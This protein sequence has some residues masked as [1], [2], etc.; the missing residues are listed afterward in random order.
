MNYGWR[1][2]LSGILSAL[3]ASIN[4]LRDHGAAYA[5][6]GA[7][8]IASI[9]FA[10][11]IWRAQVDQSVALSHVYTNSDTTILLERIALEYEQAIFNSKG[12]SLYKYFVPVL[13]SKMN[14]NR[15]EIV[16]H[17]SAYLRK[18]EILEQCYSH[19]VSKWLPI[20][21]LS[22]CNKN[23]IHVLL[24]QNVLDVFYATR[25]YLYCDE[26]VSRIFEDNV[27]R[28]EDLVEGFLEYKHSGTQTRIFRSRRAVDEALAQG[29]VKRSDPYR[30]IEMKDREETC[31][32]YRKLLAKKNQP[33]AYP[34]N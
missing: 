12:G 29:V 22:G 23:V 20:Q 2:W 10:F 33:P 21:S 17:L 27:A 6:I 28:L 15:D 30:V 3:Y 25:T 1:G 32:F 16:F 26:G 31:N 19:K 24:G 18:V 34:P 7:A 14:E 9:A 8:L 4:W 5:A 13:A 11:Q